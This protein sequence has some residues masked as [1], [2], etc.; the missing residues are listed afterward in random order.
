M[1]VLWWGPLIK[2][3]IPALISSRTALVDGA[4]DGAVADEAVGSVVGLKG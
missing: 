1:P 2:G 4:P 3:D